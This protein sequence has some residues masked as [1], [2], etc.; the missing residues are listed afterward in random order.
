VPALRPSVA[1]PPAGTVV[2]VRA[3]ISPIDIRLDGDVIASATTLRTDSP[4]VV[5]LTTALADLGLT[6]IST[7]IGADDVETTVVDLVLG[8]R[9]AARRG[10]RTI[11]RDALPVT[12]ARERCL[13][14]HLAQVHETLEHSAGAIVSVEVDDA[15]V[16]ASR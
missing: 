11:D 2:S 10:V 16:E 4:H 1:S 6:V 9:P 12:H 8:R 14:D 3:A 13:L 7:Y 5:V 15:A